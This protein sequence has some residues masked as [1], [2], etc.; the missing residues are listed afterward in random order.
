MKLSPKGLLGGA[1]LLFAA[2]TLVAAAR[3]ELRRPSRPS[4]PAAVPS[5][6]APPG[7]GAPSAEAGVR[8]V[9]YYFTGKI[10]C[11]TCVKIE[12]GARG[13]IEEAFPAEL[14]S[15]RLRF[16]VVD[17]DEPANR[18]Y[19]DE[20]GLDASQLVLVRFDGAERKGWRVLPEL[21]TL[22]E[23]PERMAPFLRERVAAALR[24][25]A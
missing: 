13:V 24:G 11:T 19:V 3:Q 18:R 10:R 15:G 16:E 25:E 14:A 9:A 7:P 22:V 20:Y 8:V 1:L 17:F 12:K 6:V 4:S 23:T 5:P 2:V 21:W